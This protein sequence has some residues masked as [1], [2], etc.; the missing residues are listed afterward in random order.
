MRRHRLV[1]FASS[2]PVLTRGPKDRINLRILHDAVSCRRRGT[3]VCRIV[4]FTF[5]LVLSRILLNTMWPH[6]QRSG[7]LFQIPVKGRPCKA[8]RGL[9]D[10]QDHGPIFF[11]ELQFNIPQTYFR[12]RLVVPKACIPRRIE[13]A[14]SQLLHLRVLQNARGPC[15]SSLNS[16]REASSPAPPVAGGRYYVKANG[17]RRGMILP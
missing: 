13:K 16:F 15:S 7:L 14:A 17:T 3:M 2:R 1:H 6:I 10:Y 5:G 4:V 8:P 12:W 11:L 9:K